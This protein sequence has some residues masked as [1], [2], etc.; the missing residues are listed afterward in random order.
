MLAASKITG[1]PIAATDGEI[2][3]VDDLLFDDASWAIRWAVADTGKW[4]TGRRVLLPKDKLAGPDPVS[5][6]FAVEITRDAVKDSPGLST[7]APVS[8]QM[9]RE[10]FG[11]YG[12]TPYWDGGYGYPMAAGVATGA[13]A[14]AAP[15]GMLPEDAP[16]EAE[17]TRDEPS[18]DPHLRSVAEVTGYGIEATDGGIGHLE[19][20]LLDPEDWSVRFI[21]VD[22]RNWWPGRKVLI[23][24]RWL[25]EIDWTER[26]VRVDATREAVKSSPDY[27][28]TSPPGPEEEARLHAHYGHVWP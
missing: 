27:D 8:R 13:A 25:R 17:A 9:E 7:D 14:P 23:S 4:L 19:D 24:P 21:V 15:L 28:P 10:V 12:W 26:T 6:G 20:L 11:H 16:S 1:L 5:E 3:R 18:G 22:T 2:G